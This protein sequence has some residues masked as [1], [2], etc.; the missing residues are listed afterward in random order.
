MTIG[1]FVWICGNT[2]H[3][4]LRVE[5]EDLSES[6]QKL[7]M[8]NFGLKSEDFVCICAKSVHLLLGWKLEVCLDLCNN[9]THFFFGLKATICLNLYKNS[10]IVHV[11]LWVE[12]YHLCKNYEYSY[13][14]WKV[15]FVWILCKICACSSSGWKAGFVWDSLMCDTVSISGSFLAVKNTYYMV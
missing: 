14:D 15:Q 2:E 8:F 5:S 13:L 12:S 6:A 10:G 7:C 3:I 1:D 9:C 11:L 4:R